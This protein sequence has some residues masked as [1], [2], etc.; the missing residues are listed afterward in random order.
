MSNTNMSALTNTW[1]V[2][3]LFIF[4]IFGLLLLIIPR[5]H[6]LPLDPVAFAFGWVSIALSAIFF[7][8]CLTERIEDVEI[9]PVD[10]V[11]GAVI[12]VT[13]LSHLFLSKEGTQ[14][15]R[16]YIV[17]ATFVLYLLIR[18][19]YKRY[20]YDNQTLFL[21]FAVGISGIEGSY[22]LIQ[23]LSNV[24]MK[25]HFYNQN[26][27][28]MYT[29]MH[30]PL[31]FA[32]VWSSE[33]KLPQKICIAL[34]SGLLLLCVSLSKCRTVYVG[35]ILTLLI[36]FFVHY[37]PS[38]RWKNLRISK[39]SIHIY[40]ILCGIS[41][42]LIAPMIFL[43]K[44]LSTIGRILVWKVSLQMFLDFPLTGVG[45][46]NVSSLYNIYQGQFFQQGLGSALERM[47]ASNNFEIFNGYLESFVEFGV[48]GIIVF[49]VFWMMI[50][51]NTWSV[52]FRTY[53]LGG[54]RSKKRVQGNKHWSAGSESQIEAVQTGPSTN[55]LSLISDN[56]IL[57]M[58]GSVLL[59][60]IMAIFYST[61]RFTSIYLIFN[62]CLACVI[63]A[64]HTYRL[65]NTRQGENE[66]SKA[67]EADNHKKNR[68]VPYT[69]RR[70]FWI[71]ISFVAFLIL[72]SRI[73]ALHNQYK[74]GKNWYAAQ[75]ISRKGQ[76]DRAVELYYNLYPSLRRDER[77]LYAFGKTL[78]HAGN[79][80]EAIKFLEQGKE[81]WPNPFLLEDLATA[82]ENVGE[83]REAL[84]NATMA[85]NI[86]PWRL[87]SK[88]M[89]AD[90][91]YQIGDIENASKYA[92]Y[93]VDTPM[94]KVTEKGKALKTRAQ[95][96][97]QMLKSPPQVLRTRR[98]RAIFLIPATYQTG[99]VEAL[100][101]A[102]S[103]EM[104]LIETIH[105]VNSEQRRALS[106]LLINMPRQDLKSL[107]TDLLAT[108]VEYAFMARSAL[109]YNKDIP[110]DIFLNY[111]LP[112]AN[113][114][115]HRDNWRADFYERF[116][117]IARNSSSV[118][119]AA[120]N[121]NT[122]IFE[123]L[124]VRFGKRDSGEA[125]HSPF[126]SM[127]EGYASCEGLSVLLADACRAV[128][129][130]S[131]LVCIPEWVNVKGGHVWVEVYNDGQ[132][133]CIAAFDSHD[134][135]W[136]CIRASQTDPSKPQHR[137]Y[138]VS[139]ERTDLHMIFGPD[140]SLIDVTDRYIHRENVR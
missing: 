51:R 114:N 75:M 79:E 72:A 11:Y 23:W 34:V 65:K 125:V 24:Q 130:P 16:F 126:E 93:V 105:T 21:L 115:E 49:I 90:L 1:K 10:G 73:P 118:E 84:L 121:L 137:I 113:V 36:M 38:I 26:Y 12:A 76:Y 27:F 54:D 128:G 6:F 108:N 86:L 57:G 127:E 91:H 22:G 39:Y 61:N 85:N 58:A 88:F 135:T 60:M 53:R 31:A 92:Q 69:F 35:L 44:P 83:L 102:G 15:D 138:A 56:L 99:V 71:A 81:L 59:F 95:I 28:A 98:E 109:S 37:G 52:F 101:A 33:Y 48:V 5:P 123:A 32:L 45:F 70:S 64:N 40:G 134:P 7:L 77:F 103:N 74:A 63:S 139:F 41:L 89:L 80:A 18:F 120:A 46:G 133:D 140:V 67:T 14:V 62:L 3:I 129:I 13:T 124:D 47:S 136:P 2:L 94:K 25:G 119:E 9:S 96:L 104:Q 110:D 66:T 4:L 132:W 87:T 107:T 19:S 112:Y 111:V 42:V 78:L 100:T 8:Y 17:F 131:R 30:V 43:L 29:A 97:Q 82:Y 68:G 117:E 55:N 20:L 50:M 116:F 106:F 122:K